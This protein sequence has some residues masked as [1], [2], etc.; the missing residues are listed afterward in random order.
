[1]DA[2]SPCAYHDCRMATD[3]RRLFS[4]RHSP[5]H[6]AG[7]RLAVAAILGAVTWVVAGRL[8]LHPGTRAILAWDVFA[9]AELA[10]AWRAMAAAPVDRIRALA[11]GEDASRVVI[12]IV[13]VA[14]A[15]MS[16]LGVVLARPPGSWGPS[17]DQLGLHL[18]LSIVA[19]VSA[20]LLIHT[21]FA[22]HYAHLYYRPPRAP[23]AITE[24][25]GLAFPGHERPAYLDFAYFSFVVGMTFQVSDVAVTERRMR[26]VVMLQSLLAFAF[27]TV[28]LA[29]AVSV[30][31]RLG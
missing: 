30:L 10:M 2:R 13:I 24:A 23:G 15:A 29:L 12:G 16:L 17:P 27:N 1:M 28:V 18:V 22:F 31:L 25:G 7:P 26:L 14:G 8:S 19:V 5:L 4:P 9:L 6:R 21:V 20:W 3:P 11:S